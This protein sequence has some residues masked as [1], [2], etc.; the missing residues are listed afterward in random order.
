MAE[1]ITETPDENVD[2]EEAMYSDDLTIPGD[3]S[4]SDIFEEG[5]KTISKYDEVWMKTKERDMER[6]GTV[7][8]FLLKKRGQRTFENK[9]DRFTEIR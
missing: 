7:N 5:K 4:D 8:S 9:M 6:G 2:T 1:K 3:Y